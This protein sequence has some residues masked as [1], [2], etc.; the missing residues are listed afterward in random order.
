MGGTREGIEARGQGIRITFRWNGERCRETLKIPATDKNLKFAELMRGQILYEIQIG[1]FD[2]ARHFPNSKRARHKTRTAGMTVS[3]AVDTWLKT[4]VIT[5]TTRN[6]YRRII[7]AHI[8]GDAELGPRPIASVLKSELALKRA[9][10]ASRLRPKT[11]NNIL[12]PLRGA[13]E[14]AHGDGI[15]ASNP[16]TALVNVLNPRR[17]EADPFTP[18]ELAALMAVIKPPERHL[19]EFAWSTGMREGELFALQWQDIDWIKRTAH[20]RGAL[21]EGKQEATKTKRA[22]RVALSHRAVEALTAM[23]AH[24]YL[25]GGT[26]FLNPDTGAPYSHA[27]VWYRKWQR[28]CTRAKVRFRPPKQL[29]HTYASMALSAGEPPLFVM[30]Q[31]GHGSLT[32]LERHYAE[33]MPTA[34][35]NAG[36][37]FDRIAAGVT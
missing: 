13:F 30:H 6:R 9:G 35:I 2:Y 14:M 20:V 10:L 27:V 1:T 29:R 18:P 17:S 22:R 4:R 37:G 8:D 7:S 31:L 24:T 28:A 3:Q 11:V 15:I 32:M 33:W 19:V 5:A 21:V 12:I 34:N 23:K 26:I 16:A 25:A 36:A